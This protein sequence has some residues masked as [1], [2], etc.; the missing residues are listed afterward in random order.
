ME[1]SMEKIKT[2]CP[3]CYQKY[4]VPEDY[5][6]KEVTCDKCQ[7]KF[8]V[9]RAKKCSHCK[10]ENPAQ[11]FHCWKCNTEF[12]ISV[13][14]D[15]TA[16]REKLLKFIAVLVLLLIC[17]GA[18]IGYFR[19]KHMQWLKK[20]AAQGNSEAML[21]L[22]KMYLT[23]DKVRQNAEQGDFYLSKLVE[24]KHQEALVILGKALF[25]GENIGLD[26]SRGVEYLKRAADAGNSNIQFLLAVIY[27]HTIHDKSSQFYNLNKY[28]GI[29]FADSK[30]SEKYLVKAANSG[31]YG[32]WYYML[33]NY[34]REN[35]N[36]YIRLLK[37]AA[38]K[39]YPRAYR[40][41]GNH[42]HYSAL[43]EEEK[44]KIAEKYY[45]QALQLGDF[46]VTAS[47]SQLYAKGGFGLER[48]TEQALNMCNLGVEKGCPETQVV[49]GDYYCVGKLVPK[50]IGEA[51][52]LY[53][54]AATKD[55]NLANSAIAKCYLEGTG[56]QQDV[57]KAI[58]Y[59]WKAQNS[60]ELWKILKNKNK[61]Y[62]KNEHQNYCE[63]I[64]AL[65]TQAAKKGDPKWQL[66]LAECY[67]YGWGGDENNTKAFQWF[68]EVEQNTK[69]SDSNRHRAQKYIGDY[70]SGNYE[71]AKAVDY[72]WKAG[73]AERLI[74]LLEKKIEVPKIINLFQVD[75]DKGNSEWQYQLAKCYLHGIGIESSNYK[76]VSLLE[77]SAKQ[78]Y[79]KAQFMLG[80]YHAGK[81][82]T[83]KYP[84][85]YTNDS[86]KS[87]QW[88]KKA[89][90][91]GYAPAQCEL[92]KLYVKGKVDNFGENHYEAAKLFKLAAAQGDAEAKYKLSQ[93][94]FTGCGVEK[95]MEKSYNYLR[96][97]TISEFP[98]AQCEMGEFAQKKKLYLE[99]FRLFQKAATQGHAKAQFLLGMCYIR[100]EGTIADRDK[101]VEYFLKSS[102]QGN[103]GAMLQL[104]FFYDE[105]EKFSEAAK[106]YKNAAQKGNST[107]QFNLAICYLKG[108]GTH[109][110]ISSAQHW[111]Q[112]ASKEGHKGAQ[113]LLQKLNSSNRR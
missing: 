100:G 88:F 85:Y 110:N 34:Y 62:S 8:F 102:E 52:R 51:L 23:G 65:Y 54:D 91:N 12:K 42:Y 3:N 67:W 41:L 16:L 29:L 37:L 32:E 104:G 64:L 63:K 6:Q 20:S 78:N 31:E 13:P 55:F 26:T 30:L 45:L 113:D 28:R 38:D 47:L 59:Y 11:A 112:K 76:A 82:D 40:S 19:W 44:Y 48:N 46:V 97:A 109:K 2:V 27:G 21:I 95:D 90:N 74:E 84:R 80:E 68:S 96:S 43:S 86:R 75:A 50:D 83:R 89:A 17:G 10:A 69:A 79:V 71:Y 22:G 77:K 73:N 93:A 72:Y 106:W 61:K 39:N 56:V 99:A 5:I 108:E 101:A 107:A 33:A 14:K 36:E 92:G 58:D 15:Y 94:Y 18:A 105:Q 4:N 60:Y 70:Y 111:L 98:E 87:V 24:K 81:Y 53:H 1:E 57:F 7:Y 49:L 35:T 66:K 103:A 25:T 9:T